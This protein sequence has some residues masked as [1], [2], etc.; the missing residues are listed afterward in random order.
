[1]KASNHHS[2]SI[3]SSHDNQ[4]PPPP[5]VVSGPLRSV[6]GWVTFV[7]G[8]NEE[9]IEEDIREAFCDYGRIKSIVL[10]ADRKT[11]LAKGYALVEY[12]ERNEAQDAINALHGKSL[13]GKKIGVS[14]AFGY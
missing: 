10:N 4:M 6:E 7:T 3:S 14:F 12:M 11:G 5:P 13:M 2:S 1:M 8:V 9:A